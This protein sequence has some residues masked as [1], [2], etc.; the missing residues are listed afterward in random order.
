MTKHQWFSRHCMRVPIIYKKWQVIFNEMF[1]QFKNL[2][3]KVER[4]GLN[5][6]YRNFEITSNCWRTTDQ[7]CWNL[8]KRNPKPQTKKLQWDGMRGAKA[9]KSNP[10]PAQANPQSVK[11]IYTTEVLNR[12]ESPESLIRLPSLQSGNGS[13]WS[14]EILLWRQI[15]SDLTVLGET[16]FH[17]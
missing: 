12:S 3:G 14:Q 11:N 5:P 7:K 2:H 1:L 10:I 8:P 4:S 17:F 9:I 15:F 16:K 6:Y 13:E